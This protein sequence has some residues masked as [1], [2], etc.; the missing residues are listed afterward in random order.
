MTARSFF[1]GADGR[2]YAPW[3]LLLFLVLCVACVVVVMIGLGPLWVTVESLT[4]IDGTAEAYGATAALL[5]AHW[6]TLRTIDRRPASHVGLD[7][8]AA[9]PRTLV[10]GWVLGVAPI[11]L[12]SLLLLSLGLLAITPAADGSSLRAGLAITAMLIPAAF[13]EELFAR[14]YLFVTLREWLGTPAAVGVTS[15]GFGLLHVPNP[16]SNLLP[17]AVVTLAGVYLAVVL[18]VTGS[19]YAAWMA[20]WG[21]NFVMAVG[22]HVAV[23]G[24]PFARPDYQTVDAG[25]DWL[26]GGAWGPEGGAVAAAAMLAGLALMYYR[27]ALFVRRSAAA[28]DAQHTERNTPNA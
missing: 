19:L 7:R 27:R 17:I 6:L 18:M 25:P 1:V 22:L 28:P 5:L 24:V 10:A 20:H 4:G 21:W 2:P 8:D 12:A 14:G 26:T 23:S 13:Y 15:V 11:A 9:L 3:R 16:G